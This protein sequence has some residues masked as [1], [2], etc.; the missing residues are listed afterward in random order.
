MNLPAELVMEEVGVEQPWQA[1]VLRASFPLEP[2]AKQAIAR[3]LTALTDLLE[4]ERAD[5]RREVFLHA[6]KLEDAELN[7][8][9][10]Q[11]VSR[12]RPSLGMGI[13]PNRKPPGGWTE[14]SFM[15]AA[16]TKMTGEEPE[17]P[18]YKLFHLGGEPKHTREAAEL[19]FGIGATTQMFTRESF[20]ELQS[21]GKAEYLPAIVDSI[22]THADFYL[23]LLDRS[24]LL[25]A[26]SPGELDTL[27]CGVE[28]Y[29]RES[30]ED[31]GVLLLSRVPLTPLLER[32][33]LTE[34]K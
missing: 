19:V 10:H 12:W 33:R 1:L 22:Y 21:K 18:A 23:P 11:N 2:V 30:P 20:A 26:R 34:A 7:S 3:F 27:M 9:F 6:W 16:A 32:I 31:G 24:S 8:A 4:A 5:L 15:D 17:L 13:W 14:S 28:V 25:T 29:I